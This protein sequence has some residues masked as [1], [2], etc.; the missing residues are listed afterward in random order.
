MHVPAFPFEPPEHW[1]RWIM[2]DPGWTNPASILWMAVDIDTA[3]NQWGLLPVHI[4]REFYRKHHNAKAIAWYTHDW[5]SPPTATA[6]GASSSSRRSSSTRPRSRSSRAPRRPTRWARAPRR[7]SSQFSDAILALG[8]D[9]PV[10]TGNNHKNEAILELIARFANYW[11]SADGV[12]LYDDNNDGRMPTDEEI[13]DGAYLAEPTLFI[14]PTC[15][16]TVR[17]V[18]RY[19]WARLGE[20]GGPGTAQREGN[21]DRQGRPLHHEPDPVRE[22]AAAAPRATWA[23]SSPRGSS[24]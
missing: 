13:L 20:R 8:W 2:V 24:T 16:Q 21:A 10:T 12:P 11:I 22:R 5:S 3:P 7:S 19:V 14:H 4:Y 1:P 15:P 6:S 9:V 17:E 23:T 18:K